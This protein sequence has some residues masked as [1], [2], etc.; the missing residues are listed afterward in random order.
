MNIISFHQV[1]D[2]LYLQLKKLLLLRNAGEVLNCERGGLLGQPCLAM[3]TS[4][5]LN[6][7]TIA[8]VDVP[9]NE[10]ST[11]GHYWC[12]PKDIGGG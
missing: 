4:K 8:A 7:N 12:Q 2:L 6:P 9:G 1:F 10:V 3:L 11:E 5:L